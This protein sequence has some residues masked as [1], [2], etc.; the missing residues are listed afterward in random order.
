[1]RE[2]GILIMA[3]AAVAGGF[4]TAEKWKER[5]KILLIFR[6]MAGCLKNRILYA[7]SA[8]PEALMEA[9]IQ[10]SK[11]RSGNTAEPGKFFMRVAE[12]MEQEKDRAFSEIW[13][14][15]EK[16]LPPEFPMGRPDRQNLLE[17]GENLGF[18]D[19]SMHEKTL[20]FY[21]EQ[22]EDSM[23]R[24][25]TECGDRVKLYRVLGMAAGLF[26]LVVLA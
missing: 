12:R 20:D 5:L 9:G 11:E 21:L 3:A 23:E 7:N 15:E 17:L 26:I 13:K 1:M 16:N 4:Y 14:E 10:Y 19:R 6:Q 18:A 22:T 25:K 2:T 8:L 24:L